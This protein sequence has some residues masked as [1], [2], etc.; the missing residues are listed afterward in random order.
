MRVAL[1]KIAW[2]TGSSSPGEAAITR[3]TSAVAFS[4]SIASVNCLVRA[5]SFSC[6]LATEALLWRAAVG[7]LLRFGF[8]FLPCR[9]LAGLP[10][11]ARRR[12]TY[13]SLEATSVAYHTRGLLCVAANLDPN[14]RDGS[15]GNALNEQMF[16]ASPPEAEVAADIAEVAFVPIAVIRVERGGSTHCRDDAQKRARLADLGAVPMGG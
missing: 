16:S 7:A 11:M 8:G 2:N 5:S 13:R 3:S 4:R 10:L 12:A 14:D 6:S 1:R 9:F 15:G